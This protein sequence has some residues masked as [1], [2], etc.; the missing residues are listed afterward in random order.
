MKKLTYTV[1]A[2][3]AF[4][5]ICG[6]CVPSY[7]MARLKYAGGGDW[8]GDRTALTNLAKFCNQNL[9][10]NFEIDDEVVEVGSASIFN[11]PLFL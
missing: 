8:Y 5:I 3:V 1:I 10:T 6:F 7:K 9:K 2:F 11:Y 4:V